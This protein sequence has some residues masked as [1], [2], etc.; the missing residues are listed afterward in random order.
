[1]AVGADDVT[2]RS[3][4][5]LPNP[6]YSGK[7]YT[8]VYATDPVTA[9]T[10]IASGGDLAPG[11]AMSSLWYP[12]GVTPPTATI[13]TAKLQTAA[14]RLRKGISGVEVVCQF[15]AFDLSTS[16]SNA[17]A[18]MTTYRIVSSS[19]FEVLYEG[20]GI[21]AATTSAGIPAIGAV[22]TGSGITAVRLY[23]QALD[24]K[25]YPG[26]VIVRSMYRALVAGAVT[27]GYKA[28][29]LLETA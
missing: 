14:V 22:A 25:S 10:A 6:N 11:A 20:W 19:Q 15:V 8:R 24:D 3:E 23:G 18:T 13:A 28:T 17:Y 16:I 4:A 2:Q 9:Y 26:R 21:A 1:M 7:V 27:T 12:Q 29:P 5:Q